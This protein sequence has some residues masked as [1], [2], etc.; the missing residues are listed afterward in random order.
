MET[1][2]TS[3]A[4]STATSR[5][6][7]H[8]RH[9]LQDIL[10]GARTCT[11]CKKDQSRLLSTIGTISA[12]AASI[13]VVGAATS[14]IIKSAPQ[15]RS[16]IAWEDKVLVL[17]FTSRKGLSI[18]NVGDGPVHLS[19]VRLTANKS[20][21]AHIFTRTIQI[22]EVVE[23]GKFSSVKGDDSKRQTIGPLLVMSHDRDE[24]FDAALI[25]A[26]DIAAIEAGRK[27][28]LWVV[29]ASASP[30]LE[31]YRDRMGDSLRSYPV[32]A[33]L[34]FSSLTTRNSHVVDIPVVGLLN[35]LDVDRCR[36][37]HMKSKPQ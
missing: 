23:T 17:Q 20:N 18:A 27:C 12:L 16:T 19:H 5:P 11:H 33:R 10:K 15:V 26:G 8:C 7:T 3:D 29:Y 34:Y 14:Y 6:T 24:D 13:S 35:M 21:G 2:D 1:L 28:F 36:T 9:C 22:D 31:G 32:S 25:D 37:A 4:P 30:L